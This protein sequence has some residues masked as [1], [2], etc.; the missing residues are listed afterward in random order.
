MPQSPIF[1]TSVISAQTSQPSA[2]KCRSRGVV[3]QGQVTQSCHTIE[4]DLFWGVCWG[5]AL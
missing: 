2:T 1:F 4:Q 3:L 5:C